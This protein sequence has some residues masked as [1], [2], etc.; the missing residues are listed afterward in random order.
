[1]GGEDKGV[2]ARSLLL[3]WFLGLEL[4]PA[5][6]RQGGAGGGWVS[7]PACLGASAS[8]PSPSSACALPR[9]A[10]RLASPEQRRRT[11]TTHA[12]ALT[13]V[14]CLD[15]GSIHPTL[16]L[17]TDSLSSAVYRQPRGRCNGHPCSPRHRGLHSLPPTR[18]NSHPPPPL[19][20]PLTA[21]R[22]HSPRRV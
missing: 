8:A 18:L 15:F 9:N 14:T 11:T 1:M 5:R 20:R 17:H 16:H 10:L 4:Q 7:A 2:S 13:R 3:G 12:H 22:G 19:L 6:T 21:S